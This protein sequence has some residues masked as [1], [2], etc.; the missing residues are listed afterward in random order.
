M[1]PN[2]L[3]YPVGERV[4]LMCTVTGWPAPDVG[5]EFAACATLDQ[6]RTVEDF[7]DI[8]VRISIVQYQYHQYQY[9]DVSES[10]CTGFS[11]KSE[12]PD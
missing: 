2:Q 8:K 9:Q 3:F 10:I 6:C 7:F 1:G 4:T 11:G 5:W 12:T